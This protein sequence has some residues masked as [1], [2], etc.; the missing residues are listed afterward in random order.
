MNKSYT[1]ALVISVGAGLWIGSGFVFPSKSHSQPQQKEASA[2]PL[3]EVRVRESVAEDM[4]SDIVV[5]GR[6]QASRRVELRAETEGQLIEILAEKGARVEEGAVIARLE[7]RDRAARVKEAEQRVKQREIEYNAAK[8]LETRG[9][10][11]RIKLAQAKADLEAARADLENRK[12]DLENTEIKAP[13]TGILDDQLIEAG[14]YVTVGQQLYTIIDLDPVEVKGYLTERQV[15]LANDAQPVR[16]QLFE[17]MSVEGHLSYVAPAA[18]EQTRTF[19]CEATMPNPNY[20]I[21]EGLTASIHIAAQKRKAHKISPSILALNDEGQI[22]VKMVD[23]SDTVRFVPVD[24]LMD[25]AEFMWVEG[26]SD[27]AHLITVGQDFVIDG[28]HVKPVLA[29]GEGLL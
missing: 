20:E 26:L 7:K 11:S 28:Q 12:V 23:E 5:T 27:K 13:F 8:T 3:V 9:F 14:D 25:T 24:I 10:N 2:K 21:V 1:L 16:V 17:K 18:D 19:M 29:T 15:G 6:T 22:G 4:Q